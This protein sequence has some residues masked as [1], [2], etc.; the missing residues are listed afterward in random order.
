LKKSAEERRKLKEKK[1]AI[2]DYQPEEFGLTKDGIH[3]A[4]KD[5]IKQYHLLEKK[6]MVDLQ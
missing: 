2:H 5:Y 6:H 3:E 1:G 4:F